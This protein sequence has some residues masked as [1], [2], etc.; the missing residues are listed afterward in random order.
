MLITMNEQ[1]HFKQ[2]KLRANNLEKLK[3]GIV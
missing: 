2:G 3:L 1:G